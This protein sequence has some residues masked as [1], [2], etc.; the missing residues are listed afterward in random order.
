[1]ESYRSIIS[2]LKNNLF[3]MENISEK[4]PEQK[5]YTN[6]TRAYKRIIHI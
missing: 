2:D 3:R 1:M 4:L 6:K 5:E